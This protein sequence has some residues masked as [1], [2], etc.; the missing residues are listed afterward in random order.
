MP[1][2]RTPNNLPAIPVDNLVNL[3][4]IKLCRRLCA[5]QV[6]ECAQ[7]IGMLMTDLAMLVLKNNIAAQ[8]LTSTGT[9]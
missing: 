7:H 6:A 1:L 9:L 8:R 3:I 2:D 4:Q 5:R